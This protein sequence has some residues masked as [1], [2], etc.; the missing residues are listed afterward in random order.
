MIEPFGHGIDVHFVD[1]AQRRIASGH[2]TVKRAITLGN[3]RFISGR[4][5]HA[6]VGVGVAH[7][8]D[9][10]QASLQVLTGDRMTGGKHVHECGFHAGVH[11]VNRVQVMLHA[12]GL[13][14]VKSVVNGVLRGMTTW[15]RQPSDV[16]RTNR[17]SSD[18]SGDRRINPARK[19][20]HD[21]ADG[22]FATV[23]RQACHDRV[24]QFLDGVDKRR[25]VV[26]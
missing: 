8:D 26:A 1:V 23:I 19:P 11:A 25:A 20:Q 15:H 10:P 21:G 9:G 22:G 14:R 7:D 2:V 16:L 13:R 3:F 6:A 24:G 12:E 4:H 5:R 17:F 18:A